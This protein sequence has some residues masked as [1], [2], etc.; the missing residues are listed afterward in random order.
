MGY[1]RS[2]FVVLSV[3]FMIEIRENKHEYHEET[4]TY[5]AWGNRIGYVVL[6]CGRT[7][8]VRSKCRAVIVS[9]LSGQRD[10]F[11]HRW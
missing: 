5:T 1:K 9:E 8:I 3:A 4:Y 10:V 7:H 6:V 11:R 2:I